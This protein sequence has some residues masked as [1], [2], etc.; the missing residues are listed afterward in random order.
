MQRPHFALH[1][2]DLS[3]FFAGTLNI[4]IAPRRCEVVRPRQ[5]IEML[6]WH[7]TE[8][9]E[10]FSFFD[11]RLWHPGGVVRAL[12]YR[13]HPQTKPEHF[14]PDDVVE[15]LAPWIAGMSYGAQVQ[16]AA[17]PQQLVYAV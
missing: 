2:L 10:T 13:P 11:A 4:C 12:I 9:A 14:Q 8:P 3:D 16:L 5:T 15:V 1:G 17:D 7:P 6:R